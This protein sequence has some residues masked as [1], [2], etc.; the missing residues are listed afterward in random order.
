MAR[1]ASAISLSSIVLLLLLAPAQGRSLIETSV[2]MPITEASPTLS[3]FQHVRFCLRYPADCK[4]DPTEIT[5]V[6]L[7]AETLETMH[8]VNRDVNLSIMPVAK[9]D[10][11][12]DG[13]WTISPVSGDCNDYAVTKR[14]ELVQK[15]FPT[16]AVRLAVVKTS[17]GIGH[18]VLVV[19]T[20]KGNLVL[21][22]LSETI[23][24]WQFT[25]YQW[26]KIQSSSD[27]RYWFEIMPRTL[28][29]SQVDRKIRSAD[30]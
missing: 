24:P 6:E 19:A 4:S 29:L 5:T 1:S 2:V 11:I 18:L 3:P 10:A 13:G 17:S 16:K 25:K 28:V 27:A 20:N 21:D 22:N 30:R 23:V 15:G 14:H 8:R 26:V 12:A 9:N 7:T